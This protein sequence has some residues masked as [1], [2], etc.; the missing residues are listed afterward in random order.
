MRLNV[1]AVPRLGLR[2]RGFLESC[3]SVCHRAEREAREVVVFRLRL[4]QTSKRR[5]QVQT[6]PFYIWSSEQ[7]PG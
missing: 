2:D 6:D 4:A 3:S 1:S 5:W 7:G